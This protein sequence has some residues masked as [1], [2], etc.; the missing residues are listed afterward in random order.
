MHTLKKIILHL[1]LL[2]IV[3][4]CNQSPDSDATAVSPTNPPPTTETPTDPIVDGEVTQYL[5]NLPNWSDVVPTLAEQA[6]APTEDEAITEEPIVITTPLKDESGAIVRD[7]AGAPTEFEEV[8]YRCTVTPY[9]LTYTPEQI[10]MYNPDASVLWA[11]GLIQGKTYA[12]GRGSLLSLPISERAP[13]IVSIPDFFNEDPSRV[14]ENPNLDTVTRAVNSMV[15]NA[16][17]EGLATPSSITFEMKTYH[18]ES[19]FAASFDVSGKYLGFEGAASG[20]YESN[21]A[22][23]TVAVHFYQQMFT[24]VVPPPQTPGDFFSNAFTSTRLQEQVALDRIG[25]DNLPV[26][27]SEI[28]YGRMMMFT[29]TSTASE[30][31]IRGTLNAAYNGIGQASVELSAGQRNLLETAKI[32]I[33]SYGGDA[34]ATIAMIRSGDWSQYFTDEAPLTTAKPLSYAFRNLDGTLAQVSEAWNYN[35]RECKAR[36]ANSGT[37]EFA[38]TQTIGGAPIPA[39][40]NT[41]TGDL[42]GDGRID[43]LFNHLSASSNQFFAALA[44]PD[45]TFTPTPAQIHAELAPSGWGNVQVVLADVNGDGFDDIVWSVTEAL[46]I[47]IYV[48]LSNGDGSFTLLP[49]Q[50][51]ENAGLDTAVLF[52]GELNEDGFADLIWNVV[53]RSINNTYTAVSNGDGTFLIDTIGF[54]VPSE[55]WGDQYTRTT[56]DVNGD[57]LTDMIWNV[58]GSPNVTRVALASLTNLTRFSVPPPFNNT[59]LNS[60]GSVQLVGDINGDGNDDVVWNNVPAARNETSIGLSERDGSFDIFHSS[61]NHNANEPW[62]F[63]DP[64]L[65]DVTGDGRDDLIW[66]DIHSTYNRIYV[67]VATAGGQFAFNMSRVPQTHPDVDDW[68]T[69][70]VHIG[71]VNGD[72]LEDMIWVFS[73]A[74]PKIVV[75]LAIP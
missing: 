52:S 75:G 53:G 26:Y 12:D 7:E 56:G 57:G 27:V 50:I 49:P 21:Q 54:S 39:P 10:V 33:T 32:A 44:N 38:P 34:D 30:E 59:V 19:D 62:M 51:T 37:F 4:A 60:G 73:G 9:T 43:L 58:G 72:R 14:V 13:I 23:T 67:G 15:G 20:D 46:G 3:V 29:F 66:N 28:V 47:P 48:G 41:Y 8:T 31:E 1:T 42:N 69:A 65:A 18:A 70:T 16:N 25:P 5:I 74:F 63:Y 71:D 11:G 45:G 2:L 40:A 6:P 35:V 22:E 64:Y 17:A 61:I 36:T 24:V 55:E 68:S